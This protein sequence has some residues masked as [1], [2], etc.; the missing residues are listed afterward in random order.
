M[1]KLNL[2]FLLLLLASSSLALLT[3]CKGDGPDITPDVPTLIDCNGTLPLVWKNN[4]DLNVDYIVSCFITLESGQDL[5][6]EPGVTVQF[7]G[8]ESGILVDKG[9]LK[10]IGNASAPITL[11]GK[12]AVKGTWKGIF[13]SSNSVNNSMEYVTVSHAGS[14]E[15]FFFDDRCGVGMYSAL[16]TSRLSIKNCTLSDNEGF[17]FFAQGVDANLSAFEGNTFIRNSDAPVFIGINLL[18]KI[19]ASSVYT[20]SGRENGK[21]Y[22]AIEGGWP[23]TPDVT[24]V[25]LPVPY[26]FLS[27]EPVTIKRMTIS[28]GAILEFEQG[29]YLNVI[30]ANA[31]LIAVGTPAEPIIFRGSEGVAGSWGGIYIANSNVL[32]RL[33][34]CVVENGGEFTLFSAKANIELGGSSL[35]PACVIRNCQIRN[36]LGYGIGYRDVSGVVLENNNFSGNALGDLYTY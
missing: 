3:S 31:A 1:L 6:I 4:P 11:E 33:E 5:V 15:Q 2:K 20:V 7:E 26:R 22:I 9:S 36:G 16:G 35:N 24:L 27:G 34:N 18:N 28:P 13:Y 21:S 14:E 8:A 12:I 23:N 32:N 29:A 30:E 17:G 25:K 10:M 19:D